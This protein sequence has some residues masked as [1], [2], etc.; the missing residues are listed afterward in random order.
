[1]QNEQDEGESAGREEVELQGELGDMIH[2]TIPLYRYGA[3]RNCIL[4]C[5]VI[6]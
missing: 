5:L 1:M 3:Y 6:P 2:W 4:I